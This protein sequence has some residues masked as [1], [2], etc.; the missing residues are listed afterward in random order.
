MPKSKKNSCC[1]KSNKIVKPYKRIR[2]DAKLR[3]QLRS[4]GELLARAGAEVAQNKKP[5][6]ALQSRSVQ[7]KLRSSLKQAN[8]AIVRYRDP[9]RTA[10]HRAITL[11][12]LGLL[13]ALVINFKRSAA[14]KARSTRSAP[15]ANSKN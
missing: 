9:H 4:S 15:A 13:S 10:R 1:S 11:I 3:G 5:K 12:G 6:Q 7:R 2:S 14:S 8:R